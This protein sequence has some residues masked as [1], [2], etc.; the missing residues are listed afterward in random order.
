M[1]EGFFRRLLKAIFGE[2][3]NRG[4]SSPPARRDERLEPFVYIVNPDQSAGGAST[5]EVVSG[6]RGTS[7]SAPRTAGRAA[8]TLGLESAAFLPIS[9]DDLKSSAKGINLWGNPWFGR[10]DLIPPADDERTKLIDR[11]LVTQGLLSP[12]QLA[13]IHRVGAEMDRVRPDIIAI[14]Q[15]A[16]LAGEAA[17]QLDREAKARIK[18]QKKAEAAKRKERRAAEIAHRRAT[19]ILFLGRGVSS[20]LG[21]RTSDAAKLASLGLPLLN[22]PAEVAAALHLSIPQLRW[23]AFHTEVATR[24][25]YIQFTVPKRSGGV[26]TLS[27]PHRKLAAAQEWILHNI[28]TKLPVEPPAQGFIV[29]RSILTNAQQHVGRDIVVNMDLE[30][31]FPSI[32]FP[33]VRS[34][35]QRI[36]YSPATATIFALLCTECPRRQVEYDGQ[37]YFVAT[38]P[39]GLPQG[40]CSSP[41]LSNQVARR[42][43]KR[44]QG[45]AA[46]MELAYTRYADDLT[47]SGPAA[48]N[49]RVGYLM[50][51]VRHISQDEGFAVNERKSRV[52]RRN[53]AQLVT[54]LV[55]NDRP[56]VRRSEVRRIR[57]ILHRART[58][59]LAAQNREG[60]DNFEAWLQG[61]IAYIGM[62]RPEVGA[63]LKSEL[64]ALTGRA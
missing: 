55:V 20:R 5:P 39:R 64:R 51:R 61:K 62:S 17:V 50:A 3:P 43:D 28:L 35:F 47:F 40:A 48:F 18:E 59:G 57:A 16:A 52:L 27:A 23:L 56:G 32:T 31:F 49:D 44:L 14:N 21:D 15:E 33:R 45:L 6:A 37:R 12:E 2:E 1:A 34:V 38:G 10:R 42:L 19:D 30:A 24:L 53:A 60:R 25:H 11:A 36:G 22:T 8:G 54:G 4:E 46:K 26:R 29:G 7:A 58:E 13:E 63:R 41:A 9:R